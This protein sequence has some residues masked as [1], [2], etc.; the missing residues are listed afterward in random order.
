VDKPAEPIHGPGRC[1]P[2]EEHHLARWIRAPATRSGL[3]ATGSGLASPGSAGGRSCHG[4]GLVGP[5]STV[6]ELGPPRSAAGE[7]GHRASAARSSV[8]LDPPSKGE[9]RHGS[10]TGGAQAAWIRHRG[11]RSSWIRHQ[12]LGQPRST[13]EGREEVWIRRRELRSLGSTVGELRRRGSTARNSVGLDLQP[14]GERRRGSTVGELGRPRS[15][16]G[17]REEAWIRRRGMVLATLCLQWRAA[18]KREVP[19]GGEG[20]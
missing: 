18:V 7:L 4:S 19:M 2:E 14:E 13:A 1:S 3:A 6:G 17:G 5:G 15:A 20:K 12:E 16:V 10:T 9:R 8:G 11:P